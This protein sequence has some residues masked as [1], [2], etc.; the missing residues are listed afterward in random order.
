MFGAS[1]SKLLLLVLVVLAVWYGYKYVMRVGQVRQ[2]AARN[3]TAGPKPSAALRAEDTQKCPAC[4]A[5]V[6]RG[7]TSCGRADCPYPA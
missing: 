1:F 7:A 2:E 4:G 3:R 6:T 5:Y